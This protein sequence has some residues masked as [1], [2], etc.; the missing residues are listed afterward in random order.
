MTCATSGAFAGGFVQVYTGDGKGKTT[1]ALGLALRAAG[2]RF[3]VVI[4]Q[5][6]KGASYTGELFALER[7]YP[8]VRVFQFGRDCRRA[9]AVRQGLEDCAGCLECFLQE[10]EVTPEDRILAKK[11]LAMA[12]DVASRGL[13]D[14]LILDEIS[15]A[16]RL[17]LVEL[18]EVLRLVDG[19]S[20]GMELVLTGRGMPEEVLARADLVTEM[21]LVKHP[22]EKG[23]S[24]R[25]GVEF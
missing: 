13:A 17:G 1:A 18:E 14:I 20:Q 3:R 22:F 2:H 16:I 4:I 23:V 7:L 6:A 21:R 19:R 8:E 25:R 5:F 11:G 24:A 15:I 9:S 10:G 12:Q